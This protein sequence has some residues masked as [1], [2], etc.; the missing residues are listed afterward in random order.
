VFIIALDPKHTPDRSYPV[1]PCDLRRYP[2]VRY[3]E[4]D[5]VWCWWEAD[6]EGGE[7]WTGYEPT[8]P[9]GR[10]VEQCE[11]EDPD[12]E[13]DEDDEDEDEDD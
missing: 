4:T 13:D 2:Q 7:E 8:R 11:E 12:A 10:T 5:P 9:Y 6:D 1:E 3:K